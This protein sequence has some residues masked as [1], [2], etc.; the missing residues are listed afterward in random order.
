MSNNVDVD[1]FRQPAYQT[2]PIFHRRWSPRAMSGET[3]S[4][5]EI[6]TLFEAARWA[7]SCFNEQPLAVSLRTTGQRALGHL[8]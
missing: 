6:N 5:T 2:E 8:F 7:P 1:G 3:L 4:N